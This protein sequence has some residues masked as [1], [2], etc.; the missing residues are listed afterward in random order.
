MY[1]KRC[2]QSHSQVPDRAHTV[3]LR[4]AS[5]GCFQR[6]LDTVRETGEWLHQPLQFESA[7]LRAVTHKIPTKVLLTEHL[8]SETIIVRAVLFEHPLAKHQ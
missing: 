3:V 2:D 4:A 5:G 7:A 8:E 6:V 1:Q